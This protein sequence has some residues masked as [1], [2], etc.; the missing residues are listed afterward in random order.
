MLKKLKF[1][2]NYATLLPILKSKMMIP[3]F[4]NITILQLL[5]ELV[6]FLVMRKKHM[7]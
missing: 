3:N 1:L 7:S 6:K 5:G 4:N 2:P